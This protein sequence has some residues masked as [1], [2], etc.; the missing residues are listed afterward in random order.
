MAETLRSTALDPREAAYSDGSRRC[1]RAVI[2]APASATPSAPPSDRKKDAAEVATP[3]SSGATAFWIAVVRLGITSPS[4]TPR[5]TRD[6]SSESSEPPEPASQASSRN[7]AHA[8][9]RPV[10]GRN[11]YRPVRVNIRPPTSEPTRLL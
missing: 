6:I 8:T 10:T 7:I 4:P 2:H 9:A 1:S 3:R 11:L 5:P